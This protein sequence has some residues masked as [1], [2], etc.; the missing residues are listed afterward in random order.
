MESEKS[1]DFLYKI[2][3]IGDSS[4]GKTSVLLRYIDGN[5]D[6]ESRSTI[7]VDFKVATLDVAG[8]NV[9]LQ[10]WDTAGQETFRTIVSSYYRGAHGVIFVYDVTAE[11]TFTSIERWLSEA[12][13]NLRQ[14]VPMLLI[15]N[16][17]DLQDQRTIPTEQG[18]KFAE[19]HGMEFL[20]ASALLNTNIREAFDRMA[21][22]LVKA[23][24]VEPKPEGA[25]KIVAGS[26]IKKK[27]G[28]CCK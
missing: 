4:V 11:Q 23:T 24:R 7:G 5:F 25:K 10:L 21:H 12:T 6:P 19:A 27:G 2:L 17:I 22:S 15:G 14:K 16:K 9:K 28:G 3:L 13:S 1:F 20:E 26:S 8:K 18:A